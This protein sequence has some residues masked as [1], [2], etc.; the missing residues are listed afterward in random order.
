MT[1]YDLRISFILVETMTVRKLLQRLHFAATAW[2]IACVVYL[3]ALG[4][5]QAGFQWWLVFSLSGYSTVMVLLVVSLYL[6]AFFHGMSGARRSR[7]E[8]PL[9]ST[10]GYMAFYVSAPL[11]GGLA[12]FL[13]TADAPAMEVSFA[14]VTLATL[15]TTFFVWIV[16]DPLLGVIEMLAPGSRRHR[17]ERTGSGEDT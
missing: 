3:V 10:D 9:T 16:M 14:H 2:F 7:I 5:R 11:L 8:H 1:V 13:G 4:L 15:K 12:A 6:F 17:A